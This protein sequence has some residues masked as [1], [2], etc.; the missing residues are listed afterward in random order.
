MIGFVGVCFSV[1]GVMFKDVGKYW[2]VNVGWLELVMVGVFGVWL[3]GLRIY[4][5]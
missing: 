3:F 1:F 4:G 2:F 5:G